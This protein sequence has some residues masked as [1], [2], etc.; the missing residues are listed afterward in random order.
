MSTTMHGTP[1]APDGG[2]HA[3]NA[4]L[5]VAQILLGVFFLAAGCMHAFMPIDRAATM[6][7]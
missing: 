6:A 7:A 5:W 2:N 3:L 1:V 4:W